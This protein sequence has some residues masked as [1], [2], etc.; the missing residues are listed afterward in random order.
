MTLIRIKLPCH[1]KGFSK[2]PQNLIGA[3]LQQGLIMQMIGSI[4]R[5]ESHK[6]PAPQD[7]QMFMKDSTSQPK[8]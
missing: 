8:T 2:S 5:P 1:K 3:P 6:D 7:I 4:L